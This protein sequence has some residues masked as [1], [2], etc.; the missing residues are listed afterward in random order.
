MFAATWM[1]TEPLIISAILSILPLLGG[2]PDIRGAW[3]GSRLRRTD[4]DSVVSF[5]RRESEQR[6]R[7][8]HPIF[9]GLSAYL[10]THCAEA[11]NSCPVTL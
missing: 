6:Q 8:V 7:R 2:I 5:G 3:V 10:G 4:D 1:E 11:L 9:G